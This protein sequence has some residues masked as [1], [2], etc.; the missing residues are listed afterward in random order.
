MK[1]KPKGGMNQKKKKM[2][3]EYN[4]VKQDKKMV[5]KMVKGSCLQ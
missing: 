1:D 2:K 3:E 5:K 4:D